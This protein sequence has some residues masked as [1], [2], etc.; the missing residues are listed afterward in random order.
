[1]KKTLLCMLVGCAVLVAACK[2]DE[3]STETPT[4]P[5]TVEDYLGEFTMESEIIYVVSA[6]GLGELP[7]DTTHATSDIRV[8]RDEPDNAVLV[9][10]TN[11]NVTDTVSGTVSAS[12][13]HINNHDYLF[14]Y[15]DDQF[16]HDTFNIALNVVHNV[17]PVPVNGQMKW[18]SNVSGNTTF[19]YNG[20]PIPVSVTG[21][22]Y[23]TATKSN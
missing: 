18:Q 10:I 15:I 5:A 6:T 20:F 2:K 17:V 3:E 16:T 21:R 1:M 9:F 4:T 12:G 11:N 13:L 7:E 23:N 19:Q 22:M 14:N 8:V